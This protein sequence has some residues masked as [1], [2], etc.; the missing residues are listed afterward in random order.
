[1]WF[2]V[3]STHKLCHTS[4]SSGSR[5]FDETKFDYCAT[6][7]IRVAHCYI[8]FRMLFGLQ[9][10][11]VI[12]PSGDM[13]LPPVQ[14]TPSSLT[15]HGSGVVNT[16]MA[17]TRRH[18]SISAVGSTMGPLPP[19]GYST[20]SG[21]AADGVAGG[22]NVAAVGEAGSTAGTSTPAASSVV[23]LHEAVPPVEGFVPNPV[24]ANLERAF[25]ADPRRHKRNDSQV[26]QLSK[27]SNLSISSLSK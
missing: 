18:S 4:S 8:L 11:Y 3:P 1:M 23:G 2:Q 16:I 13:Q 27:L 17:L 26:S 14:P 24:L 9:V 5:L 15:P 7:S 12:S 10:G 19:S 20:A 21:A 25:T 6:S 22:L